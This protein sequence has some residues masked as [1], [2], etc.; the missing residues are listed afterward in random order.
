MKHYFLVVKDILKN[1]EYIWSTEFLKEDSI[2]Q[3]LET[4]TTVL[5]KSYNTLSENINLKVKLHN[6]LRYAEIIKEEIT[7]VHGLLWTS[8]VHN[9]EVLYVVSALPIHLIPSQSST[10]TQTECQDTDIDSDHTDIDSDHTDFTESVD[11]SDDE[12]E[13]HPVLS[14]R[15]PNNCES[16]TRPFYIGS[17]YANTLFFPWHD[18]FKIELE[19]KLLLPNLGLRS[20]SHNI[21]LDYS[22]NTL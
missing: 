3:S 6:E 11:S 8:T 22:P 1:S 18:N 5:S 17:G 19:E 12:N 20:P 21:V 10:E 13:S 2:Q 7:M 4:V 16:Q 15:N 9:Q 14:R